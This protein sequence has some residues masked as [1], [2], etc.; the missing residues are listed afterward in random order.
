MCSYCAL[1]CGKAIGESKPGHVED[2]KLVFGE[3][4]VLQIVLYY[5]H[6][7]D[8]VQNS[9]DCMGYGLAVRL[10]KSDCQES[11]KGVEDEEEHEHEQGVPSVQVA[12]V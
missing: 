8:W 6:R 12:H 7:Q 1:S 4:V 9:K 11:T 3:F 5:K 10:G 2:I